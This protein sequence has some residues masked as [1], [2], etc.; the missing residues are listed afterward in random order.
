ML[1]GIAEWSMSTSAAFLLHKC[2][3]IAYKGL[4][5]PLAK[6]IKA[7]VLCPLFGF[8]CSVRGVRSLLFE[9]EACHYANNAPA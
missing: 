5:P 3:S 6:Q 8:E 1:D 4:V 7:V 2:E 9:A